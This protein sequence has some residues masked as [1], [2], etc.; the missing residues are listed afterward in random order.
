MDKGDKRD[1]REESAQTKKPY[2]P[3]AIAEELIMSVEWGPLL[4]ELR[5]EVGLPEHSDEESVEDR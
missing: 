1:Y 2:N 5:A 4:A 3:E